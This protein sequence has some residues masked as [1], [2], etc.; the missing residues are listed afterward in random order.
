MLEYIYWKFFTIMYSYLSQ[1]QIL[2]N[3]TCVSSMLQYAEDILKSTPV[4]T[5][6]TTLTKNHNEK[7]RKEPRCGA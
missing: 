2:F 5:D 1:P 4:P 6:M 7:T 3:L